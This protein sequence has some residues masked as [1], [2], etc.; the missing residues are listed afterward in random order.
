MA[1]SYTLHD[2]PEEERPRERLEKV[3]VNNSAKMD[4]PP[5]TEG[6]RLKLGKADCAKVNKKDL[7]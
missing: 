4:G 3:G 2:L 7:E 6:D 1:K 5:E